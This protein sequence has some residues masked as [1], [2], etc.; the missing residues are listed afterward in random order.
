MILYL[1]SASWWYESSCFIL[2]IWSFFIFWLFLSLTLQLY[3][4]IFFQ[5]GAASTPGRAPRIAHLVGILFPLSVSSLF[6]LSLVGFFFWF[7]FVCSGFKHLLHVCKRFYGPLHTRKLPSFFCPDLWIALWAW[8]IA[9]CCGWIT[10]CSE[11]IYFSNLMW[12]VAN[13]DAVRYNFCRR[14]SIIFADSLCLRIV[15]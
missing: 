13:L 10:N 1:C 5:E 15:H 12:T 4:C 11:F 9:P 7:F 6:Q 14:K 3:F 2:Y 8:G